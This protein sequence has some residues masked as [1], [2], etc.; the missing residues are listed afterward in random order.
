MGTAAGLPVE[1]YDEQL[2]PGEWLLLH[3]DGVTEARNPR[4]ETFGLDRFVDFV[5]RHIADGRPAPETLR[6]LIRAIREYHHDRLRD[7]ATIV[8]LQWHGTGGP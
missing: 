5:I 6:R 1:L 3:T 8:L 7:D 4:G 2:E